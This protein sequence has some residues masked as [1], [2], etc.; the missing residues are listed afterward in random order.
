MPLPQVVC[1][2][3]VGQF[4]SDLSLAEATTNGLCGETTVAF[5]FCS[6]NLEVDVILSGA[7]TRKATAE[8]ASPVLL[9]HADAGCA[10]LA[11]ELPTQW[12]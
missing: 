6:T 3:D 8:A 11:G 4:W 1:V 2:G 12:R 7:G 9:T 10:A 5:A